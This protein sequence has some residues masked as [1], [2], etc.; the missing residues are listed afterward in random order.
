MNQTPEYLQSELPAIEL[1]Q[2]LGYNYLNGSTHDERPSINDVVLETRLKNAIRRINPWLN[3]NNVNNAFKEI[4]SFSS[5]S[6][7][8][9]NEFVHTLLSS[10]K[11]SPK[12]TIDGK[13][14]YKGVSFI[15]FNNIDN[16]DFLVVNQMKFK[17]QD[18][19][20]IPDIVV[21]I[22]GLP[23]AVIECKSPKASGAESDAIN[24][25]IYYQ[26]NSEK[27]FRYNQ[28]CAAIYK[29]GGRY[30]AVGAKEEHYQVYRSEDNTTLESLIQREP[31]QQDVLI[32]SVP[33]SFVQN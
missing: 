7:I 1:F 25:L 31:T 9:A 3:D 32:Y 8:E 17:G 4:T 2:K 15:D 19:N 33:I 5:A 20:T 30:G 22:N 28:L 6:T 29:V 11:Y 10:Q 21:F 23:L 13:E 27:L 12:Q 18:R 16:N 24:D 14:T 26:K